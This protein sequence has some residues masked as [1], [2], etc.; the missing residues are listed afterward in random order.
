[1][2]FYNLLNRTWPANNKYLDC[3]CEAR[4]PQLAGAP[5]RRAPYAGVRNSCSLLPDRRSLISPDGRRER[6]GWWFQVS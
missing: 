4:D 2:T 1:M 5:D 6:G 3:R